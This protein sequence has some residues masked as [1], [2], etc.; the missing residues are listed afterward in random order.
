MEK[1]LIQ[2]ANNILYPFWDDISV[3]IDKATLPETK[4]ELR[5]IKRKKELIEEYKSDCL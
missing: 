1:D 5:R 3:L 4:D 2:Q